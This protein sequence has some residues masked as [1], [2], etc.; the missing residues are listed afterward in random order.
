MKIQVP[1]FLMNSLTTLR[2]LSIR[3]QNG[4]IRDYNWECGYPDSVDIT[5]YKEF[6]D[7]WG[8]ATRAVQI[9]PNECWQ[10]SPRI[11]ENNDEEV[12]E[13]E[14]A[15][16]DL[17]IEK[18]LYS[19]LNRIDILSGIGRYGILLLGL[20]DKRS[21]EKPVTGKNLDLIYL[22]AF[23]ESVITIG[24][25]ESDVTSPRYGHPVI[26]N[27]QVQDVQ[28]QPSKTMGIHWTRVVHVADNR[29]SDE[30]FGKP[31][32]EPI[33]N[34]IHDIRK[35]GGGS[36]EMFWKGGFP[37][38]A[39]TLDPKL[40]LDN[41][42]IDTETLKD[43]IQNYSEGLKRYMV[44]TGAQATNLMPNVAD[45]RGHFEVLLKLISIAI[46]VPQ[47]V[48][49]GTEAAKL[50]SIQ[51][52]KTWQGRIK[53]RQTL[54]LTPLL[55]R[56]VI[57]R[58]IE[59]EILPTPVDGYRVEWPD[60]EQP[61]ESDEV[62][63][64]KKRTEAIAMY[65]SSGASEVMSPRVYFK[66]VHKFKDADIAMIEKEMSEIREET[67]EEDVEPEPNAKLRPNTDDTDS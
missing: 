34:H 5:K 39:I 29:E 47:R 45:P 32:L 54:Y 49:L 7:R 24:R 48:L 3:E 6:Y 28:G 51:D 40:D 57:D 62:D 31:R 18:N 4:I 12:T 56:P 8:I 42:T 10:V 23:D 20:S 41:V 67:D 65:I 36:A 61:S 13:F 1:K 66:M 63:V 22:R 37:G 27:V 38:T 2:Q 44:L 11:F 60:V 16:V 35:I 17:D 9:W 15:V 59:Y 64:A 46:G 53:H 58:L 30:I 21:L 14:K 52:K 50:S 43:E 26:Y 55:V 25:L 33:Y 19:F